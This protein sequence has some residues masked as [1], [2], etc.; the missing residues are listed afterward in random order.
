MTKSSSL[1]GCRDY[2]GNWSHLEAAEKVCTEDSPQPWSGKKRSGASS[3]RRGPLPNR[4]LCKHERYVCNKHWFIFVVSLMCMCMN[5]SALLWYQGQLLFH[6]RVCRVLQCPCGMKMQRPQCCVLK[7][8]GRLFLFK[9]IYKTTKIGKQNWSLF[10]IYIIE[11][12]KWKGISE[13]G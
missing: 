1:N 13:G 2:V 3:S 4:L 6:K 10:I 12:L 11:C 7:P 9:V 8:S 5:F